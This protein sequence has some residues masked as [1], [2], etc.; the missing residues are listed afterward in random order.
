MGDAK[1]DRAEAAGLPDGDVI[2]VLLQQHALIRDL[3]GEVRG[4]NG[5]A[6]QEAFDSLRALL[7]V[8]ETAEE[9]VLRPV[10]ARVAGEAV[11]DAR[12][13]EEQEANAVLA[14]L[15]GLDLDDPEFDIRLSDFERSVIAHAEAEEA[16]EFAAIR[17]HCDEAERQ[18]LGRRIRAAERL[19]PTHPRPDVEPGSTHQKLVGPF[20]GMVDRV[21]DT[22]AKAV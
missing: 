22:L 19:A 7:A 20:A 6:K 10:S 1:E 4:A 9:L 11:A 5:P 17:A 8:H 3:F 18:S 12:N 16:E 14:M 21:K 13:A 2:A 15:E